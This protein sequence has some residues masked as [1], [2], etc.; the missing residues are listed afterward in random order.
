MKELLS[1]FLLFISMQPCFAQKPDFW[2]D[3]EAFRKRDSIEMPAPGQVLFVGS[4]SFTLWTDIQKYFP[5]VPILNRG[6]G[7]SSLADLL[8]YKEEVIFK[9]KPKQIVMYCGENDFAAND[10]VSVQTVVSRF[11]QLFGFTR[12]RLG[13][14][15]FVYVSMKPSPSRKYLMPKFAKA[16]AEIRSFLKRYRNTAFIDVYRAMLKPDGSPMTDIFVEDNLHMNA[17][18]YAIWQKLLAPYLLN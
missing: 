17:K 14:I 5:S 9:Y 11:K 12:Q 4:S 1:V 15:S 16:N 3:I 18:G 6:F 8:R 10:T 7:G 13:N 2:D